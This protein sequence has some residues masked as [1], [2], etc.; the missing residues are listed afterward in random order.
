MPDRTGYRIRKTTLHAEEHDDVSHLTPS[1]RIEMVCQLT[2][3]VW[4]FKGQPIDESRLPR[5]S[6][7]VSIRRS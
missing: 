3:D 4:A 7:F 1:Q 6:L 5:H 2:R